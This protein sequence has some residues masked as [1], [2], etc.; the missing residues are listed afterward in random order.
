MELIK[1]MIPMKNVQNERLNDPDSKSGGQIDEQT[2]ETKQTVGQK[3]A[4]ETQLLQAVKLEA[5]GTLT[6]GIAHDF[7]NILSGIVGYSE[8]ALLFAD[9][10]KQVSDIINKILETCE[11]GRTLIN[12]MLTFSRHN[13][14]ANDE[15]PINIA[16]VI[17]EVIKYLKSS[18]PENI[19]IKKNIN[20]NAGLIMASPT[21][22][23]QV[24]MNLC[25]NAVQAMEKNGGVLTIELSNIKIDVNDIKVYN[26]IDPGDYLSLTIC[27]NGPGVSD[28][29][30]GKIFD[31]YFTTKEKDEGTGLGLSIVHGVVKN[32]KGSISVYSE[33][34]VQTAFKILLPLMIIPD[35]S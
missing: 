34:S 17:N 9:K 11:R 5:M 8:V 15:E 1:R 21:M 33:P 7:N 29:I 13:Y 4:L 26:D 19:E 20:K 28:E 16:P 12:N 24:I 35:A 14:K 23:H 2:V 3:K 6:S 31:P 10:N 22:I 25:T 32:Y 27:D 30:I 18:L